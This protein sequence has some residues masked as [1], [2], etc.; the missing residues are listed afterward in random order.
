MESDRI[1][2]DGEIRLITR[3]VAVAFMD[4]KSFAKQVRQ[5]KEL[6]LTE[7]VHIPAK[8]PYYNK[9]YGKA[10]V[11]WIVDATGREIPIKTKDDLEI[12]RLLLLSDPEKRK[13]L[14]TRE[15]FYSQ[16]EAAEA[17]KRTERRI[18]GT[19]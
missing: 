1:L 11:V 12:V 16:K 6:G 4:G 14:E 5:D 8:G 18:D 7:S 3:W 13:I 9:R 2:K 19:K 17:E 10:E 15:I